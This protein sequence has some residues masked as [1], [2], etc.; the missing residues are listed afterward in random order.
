MNINFLA[1]YFI[2]KNFS[3]FE[4]KGNGNNFKM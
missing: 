3:I 4:F 1:I 2:V